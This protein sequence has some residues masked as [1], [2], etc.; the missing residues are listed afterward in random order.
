MKA[1]R[2]SIAS[3]KLVCPLVHGVPV[4]CLRFGLPRRRL[5]LSW[6]W[7]QLRKR[8]VLSHTLLL[9]ILQL[10]PHYTLLF[11]SS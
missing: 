9:L 2:I 11:C 10:V 6:I 5:A 3:I 8:F 1:T 7:Y 4:S